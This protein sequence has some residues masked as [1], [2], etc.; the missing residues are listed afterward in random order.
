VA[1]RND[2]PQIAQES[3]WMEESHRPFFTL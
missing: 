2:C 3:P 1:G